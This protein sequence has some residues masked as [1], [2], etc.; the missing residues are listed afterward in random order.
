MKP[1]ISFIITYYNQ[2]FSL[3]EDCLNSIYQ[4]PLAADERE[5]IVIDDG[6]QTSI[7][8][9]EAVGSILHAESSKREIRSY[10]Q[11]NQGVSVARN[12]G[13]ELAQGEYIQFVDA[14][15]MLMPEAYAECLQLIRGE[16]KPDIVL[17][18]HVRRVARFEHPT[19][20]KPADTLTGITYMRNHNVRGTVWEYIFRKAIAEDCQ[21]TEHVAYGEDEEF[22][23][24]L[25]LKA[26]SVIPTTVPA[27]F[28]RPNPRSATGMK[29]AERIKKRLDD[30]HGVIQR[31]HALEESLQ[32]LAKG[33]LRRKVEQ[34]TMDYLYNTMRLTHSTEM[35]EQRVQELTDEGFFPLPNNHY[36]FKY[37]W[38]RKIITQKWSRTILC[39]T[40]TFLNDK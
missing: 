36:T 1:L 13:L 10:R 11:E 2:S 32:P 37:T 15:D 12:K 24:R 5:V 7:Y 26:E 9:F 40:L 19:D 39:K 17:F 23:T 31:L 34:L 29:D 28:Y 8:N 16:R 38:F 33:S 14:D 21:F 3:L 25:M 22:T 4:L 6:S 18:R 35:L 20:K 27:Y 30:T